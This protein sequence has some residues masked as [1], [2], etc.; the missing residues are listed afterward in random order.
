VHPLSE[1]AGVNRNYYD[2][3]GDHLAEAQ[4]F[5]LAASTIRSAVR[6]YINELL[7]SVF[8]QII[9]GGPL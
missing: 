9:F 2:F 5:R 1:F 3:V 7:L 4:Y 6:P 8:F